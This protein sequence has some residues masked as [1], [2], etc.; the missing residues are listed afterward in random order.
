MTRYGII[1]YWNYGEGDMGIFGGGGDDN[2]NSSQDAANKLM[3][4]QIDQNNAEL[5]QKR[6]D[7]VQQRMAI[8]KSQGAETWTPD[9]NAAY[10]GGGN[11]PPN[12]KT[13]PQSGGWWNGMPGD[14]GG[15]SQ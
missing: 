4:E 7:L 3:Q 9:R 15:K 6:Q 1:R 8:V 12:L 2:D 10:S 13:A 5:E 11:N 14:M